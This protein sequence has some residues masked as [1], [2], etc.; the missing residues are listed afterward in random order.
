MDIPLFR[1][2]SAIKKTARRSVRGGGWVR[3][4]LITIVVGY[5]GI[6]ILAPLGALIAGAFGGVGSYPDRAQQPGVISA[7]WSRS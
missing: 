4:L 3:I 2:S 7:F 1:P 6:L 5:V